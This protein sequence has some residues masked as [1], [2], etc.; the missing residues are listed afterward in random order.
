MTAALRE[1]C[2]DMLLIPPVAQ[3]V[4]AGI[5]SASTATQCQMYAVCLSEL[6]S[7]GIFE[8]QHCYNDSVSSVETSLNAA[9]P[10]CNGTGG[11]DQH[12][13]CSTSFCLPVFSTR[14]C[15]QHKRA[16]GVDNELTAVYCGSTGLGEQH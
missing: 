3:S 14:V 13:T 8:H 11:R 4:R 16:L 12:Q 15:E 10:R 9:H 2:H 1:I 5:T 6:C 7:Y